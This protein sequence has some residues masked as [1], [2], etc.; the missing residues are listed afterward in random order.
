MRIVIAADVHLGLEGLQPDGQVY[1]NL[2][3]LLG[4]AVQLMREFGPQ[5]VVLLGDLVNRGYEAE[6]EQFRELVPGAFPRIV[7]VLGNHE[8]QRASIADFERNMHVRAFRIEQLAGMTAIILNSGVEGLPDSQ[9]HG[10]LSSDQLA[11]LDRECLRA[12]H[13]PLLVFVHH[14]IAGTTRD[15]EKHMFGLTNGHELQS[16]LDQLS[17][18][19]IVFSAH[20]HAASFVRRGNFCYLNA[21]ALGFWPHSFLVVELNSRQVEFTTVRVL[22]DPPA[23]PDAQARDPQYRA[24]RE[25]ALSDQR[26]S[27]SL[28]P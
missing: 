1:G 22:N 12:R 27:I 4:R 7:P 14:P 19:A 23:S 28:A 6:Y 26:G 10:T 25:G 3:S 20:T 17:V 8:L 13:G 5:A 9:W 15:S 24:A 16:R 2:S 21:P 18:P 11:L